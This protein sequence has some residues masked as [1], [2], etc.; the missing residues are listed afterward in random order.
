MIFNNK[1]KWMKEDDDNPKGKQ[2]VGLIN[3][4]RNMTILSGTE[5]TASSHYVPLCLES[6]NTCV[7]QIL[8]IYG[9][10]AEPVSFE[11]MKKIKS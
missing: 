5:T 1:K 9:A 8:L 11:K 6:S 3:P 7:S 10:K 2:N 4:K